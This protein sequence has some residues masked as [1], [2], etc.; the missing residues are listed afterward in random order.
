MVKL[1][2]Q[3]DRRLL[4]ILDA[5]DSRRVIGDETMY[6]RDLSLVRDGEYPEM[7]LNIDPNT[8]RGPG[9]GR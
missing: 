6:E 4:E 1:D 5:A 7:E 9:R 2:E 8:E 3:G